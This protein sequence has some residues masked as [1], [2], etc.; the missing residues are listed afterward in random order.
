MNDQMSAKSEHRE[1][2]SFYK[3]CCLYLNHYQSLEKTFGGK[4]PIDTQENIFLVLG[5]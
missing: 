5:H 2:K 3:A 1:V 4:F